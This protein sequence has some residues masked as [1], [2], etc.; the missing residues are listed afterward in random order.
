MSAFCRIIVGDAQESQRFVSPG[1]VHLVVTSP[2]YFGQRKYAAGSR[3]I[4]REAKIGEYIQNLLLVF[5]ETQRVLRKDGLLF[6][7]I[8]DKTIDGEL[9]GIPW[10]V[11]MAMMENG[12]RLIQEIVWAKPNP[13]PGG[14]QRKCVL[15]HEHVFCFALRDSSEPYFY[16]PVGIMEDGADAAKGGAP[17]R[18]CR[19]VWNLSVQPYKGVHFAT[20]P[21]KLVERCILAGTS[22]H[23]ACLRC[24]A[25]YRR[26]ITKEKIMRVRPN[27]LTKRTGEDGTGNYCPNDVAGVRIDTIGWEPGCAHADA[28]VTPSVV[29]DPFFGAGTTGL[30]AVQ[31][32]R[33]CIGIEL[34]SEYAQQ[35][36][37]RLG[38]AGISGVLTE[39]GTP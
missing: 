11:A 30:V 32:G 18:Y 10:R 21:P 22:A 31:N 36:A 25:Q 13:T 38:K 20:F 5:D 9:R 16:D 2:P 3:E 39:A 12:W 7:N 4:G 23:G 33:S 19:S 17:K 28:P 26:K 15:A 6:L 29:M 1:S 35:A 24:G 8:G 14:G 37:D 34:N 27:S